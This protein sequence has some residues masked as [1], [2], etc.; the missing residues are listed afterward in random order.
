MIS[1]CMDMERKLCETQ[2]AFF[3]EGFSYTI[4]NKGRIV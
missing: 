4:N 1:L 3:V 2:L